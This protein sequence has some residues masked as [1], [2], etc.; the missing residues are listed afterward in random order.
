MNWAAMP[1][2]KCQTGCRPGAA[3]AVAAMVE[4]MA[5]SGA[6]TAAEAKAASPSDTP[7]R[8]S[9][10]GAHAVPQRAG[11][12]PVVGSGYSVTNTLATLA[13]TAAATSLRRA[14]SA[15]S[16]ADRGPTTAG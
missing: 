5:L 1:V 2:T 16:A 15:A 9:K 14:G 6:T 11:P 3:F 12:G 4:S 13:G 10:P 8:P 7:S